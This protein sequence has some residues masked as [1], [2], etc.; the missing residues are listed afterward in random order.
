MISAHLRI[1]RVREP[2]ADRREVWL[3]HGKL[4]GDLVFFSLPIV[5]PW[6]N[7]YLTEQV[8]RMRREATGAAT[9][10]VCA[11][12]ATSSRGNLSEATSLVS[13]WLVPR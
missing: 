10:A 5:A 11:D 7:M 4:L 8:G 9:G 13:T 12:A 1:L 3:Q 2:G 6:E